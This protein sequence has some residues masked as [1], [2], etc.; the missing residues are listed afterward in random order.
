MK[1]FA[2]LLGR[3]IQ[4]IRD[5]PGTDTIDFIPHA[6]VPFGTT[7]TYG[8]IFYTYRPQKKEKHRT[9]LT[10]GGNLFIC[11]YDLSAPSSDITTAKLIFNS[12]ISMPGARFI[13][14]D[15]KKFY[16]KTP[17]PEPSYMNMKIDICMG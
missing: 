14:L 1:L 11:L 9:R 15:F 4:G 8:R 13:T 7:V 5:V 2:N 16:L 17:L 3:L 12:V 6:E 10:I